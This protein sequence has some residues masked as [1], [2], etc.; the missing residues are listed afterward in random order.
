MKLEVRVLRCRPI[1][2]FMVKLNEF[3][4]KNINMIHNS[5]KRRTIIDYC[6]KLIYHNPISESLYLNE[7]G[8]TFESFHISTQ[9]KFYDIL[10]KLFK[11][12]KNSPI[13]ENEH[14]F[15]IICRHMYMTPYDAIELKYLQY[16]LRK[17]SSKINMRVQFIPKVIKTRDIEGNVRIVENLP[18]EHLPVINLREE[19]KL[20]DEL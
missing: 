6:G 17:I 19:D 11:E 10:L 14:E 4:Q 15:L 18:G 20:C 1:L 3:I 7:V 12:L 13:L 8:V 5:N 9:T 16:L 2:H